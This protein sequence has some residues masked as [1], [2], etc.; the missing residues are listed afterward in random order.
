MA[1]Y[2]DSCRGPLWTFSKVRR[3]NKS[4]I[5]ILDLGTYGSLGS[6]LF[7]AKLNKQVKKKKKKKKKDR[8]CTNIFRNIVQMSAPAPKSAQELLL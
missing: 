4:N 2:G 5:S 3:K 1:N 7:M 8:F 6:S